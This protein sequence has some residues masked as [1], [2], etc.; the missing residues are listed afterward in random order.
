MDDH[1]DIDRGI[2]ASFEPDTLLPS[3][4]FDRVRRRAGVPGE[5]QL[6]LAVVEDAVNIYRKHAA[7]TDPEHRRLFDEA[8]AWI[9]DEDRSWFFSFESLCDVLGLDPDY[10][11][12]GLRTWKRRARRRS[13]SEADAAVVRIDVDTADRRHASGE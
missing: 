13:A 5:W 2:P 1:N 12:R 3:Q 11:R 7:A 10:L 9:E 6:V 4:Y 8:E